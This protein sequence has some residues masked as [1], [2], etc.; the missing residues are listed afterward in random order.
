MPTPLDHL[1]AISL[2]VDDL[3]AAMRFYRDAL[4]TWACARPIS[5]TQRDIAGKS[6][7]AYR[8]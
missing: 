2:F 6:H 7:N 8:E 5:S 1:S 3:P 4:G